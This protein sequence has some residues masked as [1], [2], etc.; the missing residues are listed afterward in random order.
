[1]MATRGIIL[2][3]L[4]SP[5][6]TEVKDV[7]KYLLEFLMDGRVIDYPYLARLLLVGGI[8]APLRAP[9]SAEAYKKVWTKEGSPLVVLTKQLQQALQP[10]VAAPVE[11]AMRYGNPSM[12]Q[13]YDNLLAKVPDLEEVIAIPLYPHYAMSS[14]ETAVEHAK[15]V[16]AKNKYT[17]K[18]DFVKPFYSEPN[19][20][21]ALAESIQPHLQQEYDQIL[22]SYHGLPQRHMKKADP[23]GCHCL[24][25][26]NC[27]EVASPAHATCYRHQCWTTTQLIAGALQIPK[28][29]VGF[30]FQSRLGREEWLKPYT[31]KRL[32]ELPGEGVKKLI[33][34]CP[35]FVSDCLETLEEIAMEGKEEF[36]HAG[37]ESYT[38]I[39]CLNTNPLWVNA[40][41]AWMNDYA[42]GSTTMLL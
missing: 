23:T 40:L 17:F 4:G 25:V 34:L 39:P 31:A 32:E 28:E 14:Y 29:K 16:H 12:Q 35:A 3:N 8:I 37:G 11:I 20:I 22:F 15:A 13:A 27:C 6:S 10:F 38:V 19:Y 18:L 7:R 41:T 2:M 42:N 1:M 33:I 30:S 24:K 21:H 26:D 9:K 36:L 5:D